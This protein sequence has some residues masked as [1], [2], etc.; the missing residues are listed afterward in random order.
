MW[1]G[2][3]EVEEEGRKGLGGGGLMKRSIK[4]LTAIQIS[5]V[6][7]GGMKG[8]RRMGRAG[9]RWRKIQPERKEKL[10]VRLPY[11][12]QRM[13]LGVERGKDAAEVGW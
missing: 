4:G 13:G 2:G 11:D 7:E 9:E 3:R 10:A 8:G 6:S 1:E 12:P 5:K